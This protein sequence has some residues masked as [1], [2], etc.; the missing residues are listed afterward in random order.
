MKYKIILTAVFI[1]LSMLISRA[2]EIKQEFFPL[3]KGSC[4]IYSG[5]VKYQSDGK[6]CEKKL[7]WKMEITDVIKNNDITVA[8]LK[9]HPA[10]LP[11]FEEGRKRGDYSIVNIENKKYYFFDGIKKDMIEKVK[12]GEDIASFLDEQD[13][14][15]DLPMV[16]EKTFPKTERNDSF[17]TWYI[18]SV[19]DIQVNIKNFNKS[20]KR[21]ILIYRTS[22]DIRT[23][24]YVKG[25]GILNYTYIHHGSV[26]ECNLTLTEY[27][28]K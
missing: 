7:T 23:I 10:D 15:I 4:W 13:L 20:A 2:E 9:G 12:K 18:Q 19:D 27:R 14:F 5:T 25:L 8:I 11:F 3:I 26:S 6:V 1:F 16:S 28:I 17:Y 24:D 22:P 21:Y